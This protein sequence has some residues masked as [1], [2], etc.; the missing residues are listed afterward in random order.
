MQSE[1]HVRLFRNGRNQA[2]RIP[3]EFELEGD[4][5][6]IHK[7][8]DKLIIEPIRKG[9]L[10]TLLATLQPLDDVFPDVDEGLMPLDDVEL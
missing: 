9:K 7:E 1:R 5:A 4:E 3:R 2:L 8:G 10:L 6:I